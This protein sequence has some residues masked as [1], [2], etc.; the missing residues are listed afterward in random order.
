MLRGLGVIPL[1][2]M[3]ITD[4]AGK[5]PGTFL[6]EGWEIPYDAEISRRLENERIYSAKVP[7]T[8]LR[9]VPGTF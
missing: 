9:K 8:I 3:S 5:V 1:N 7:V 4:T 2:T 6:L